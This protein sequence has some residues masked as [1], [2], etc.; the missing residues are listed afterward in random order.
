MTRQHPSIS[1]AKTGKLYVI[2]FAQHLPSF[3][4]SQFIL[5]STHNIMYIYIC[6]HTA[7]F[8]DCISEVQDF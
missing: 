4:P 1:E 8:K 3:E 5:F 6:R 2:I 7:S